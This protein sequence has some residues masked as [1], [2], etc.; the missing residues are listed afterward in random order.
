MAQRPLIVLRW[1]LVLPAALLTT[2][3]SK[4]AIRILWENGINE[5]LPIGGTRLEPFVLGLIR[6]NM[7]SAALVST[8]TEIAP[9]YKL[10][11]STKMVVVYMGVVTVE[12]GHV[13][14]GEHL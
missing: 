5:V 9:R 14:F 2:V 3:L 4:F 12:A 13:G 8:G 1:A 10:L 6:A 7:C 11:V